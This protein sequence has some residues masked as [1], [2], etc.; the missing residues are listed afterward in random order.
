[1]GVEGARSAAAGVGEAGARCSRVWRPRDVEQRFLD[2]VA[3]VVDPVGVARCDQIIADLQDVCTAVGIVEAGVVAGR[4]GHMRRSHRGAGQ[5]GVLAVLVRGVDAHARRSQVDL[6][7]PVGEVGKG[8]VLV[9]T[10]RFGGTAAG[11][12]VEVGYRRYGD[13]IGVVGGEEARGVL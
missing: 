10:A 3:G 7:A 12:S 9:R 8:I 6:G 11:L 1:G 13:D 2:T 4:A 5:G